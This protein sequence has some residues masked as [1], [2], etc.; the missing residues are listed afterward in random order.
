MTTEIQK[1]KYLQE[2]HVGYPHQVINLAEVF[3]MKVAKNILPGK[4]QIALSS[5]KMLLGFRKKYLFMY[6]NVKYVK[7]EKKM[8]LILTILSLKT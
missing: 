7:N 6:S 4:I 2:F 8:N 3:S 1:G 5:F